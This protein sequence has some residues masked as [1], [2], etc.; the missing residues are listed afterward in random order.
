MFYSFLLEQFC[1]RC[2]SYVIQHSAF[3]L[4]FLKLAHLQV[5]VQMIVLLEHF[6]CLVDVRV[7]L[8]SSLL[9]C[10]SS[11]SQERQDKLREMGFVDILHKL[12]QSS[13]PN[14]SDRWARTAIPKYSIKPN[15]PSYL[16][17]CWLYVFPSGLKRRCSSTWH[18]NSGQQ[19]F[20]ASLTNYCWKDACYQFFGFT[21]L[22][23][24]C[25]T[26]TPFFSPPSPSLYRARVWLTSPATQQLNGFAQSLTHHVKTWPL[27]TFWRLL[28]CYRDF[29]IM[30]V[31]ICMCV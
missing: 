5:S 21:I 14:L 4:Q 10:V 25:C 12:T 29:E 7:T 24:A 27:V 19:S 20:N 18:D 16:K 9:H 17:R 26:K 3:I 11:G 31:C 15:R 23:L 1:W 30:L 8:S 28:Y 6:L 22:R 2:W 13:D